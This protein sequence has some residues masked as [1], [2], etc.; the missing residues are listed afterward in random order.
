MKNIPIVIALL[1]LRLAF[2]LNGVAQDYGQEVDRYLHSST[3][4]D[5]FSEHERN[6]PALIEDWKNIARLYSPSGNEILR[7]QYI[8]ERFREY[9]IP[10]AYIDR[11]GN[12]VGLIEGSNGGPTVVF[13]GTM[14]DL[15]TVAEMVK[16][17]DR[18][19]EERNGKLIGPG[20]NIGATCTAILGLA[21]LF[22]LP[23][24]H[25]DGRI[26]IVGVVQEETGLQGIKGFLEDHPGEVDYLVDIMSGIGSVTYGALGIHWFKIHFK[27]ERGHTLSGG[28]PNVTRSV[29]RAVDR[30]FDIPVPT[31]PPEKRTYLNIAML[32]AGKVYNHK[33]DDGWFSV[34]LRSMDNGTLLET[35]KKIFDCVRSVAGEDQREWW[36]ETYSEVPAGQIPGAR[37]SR[38]VRTAEEVTKALGYDVSLSNRGSSNMNVGISLKIPSISV[39]G[40]RG[41]GRDTPEEYANIKPN[42][43]GI[44]LNFL[45]GFMLTNGKID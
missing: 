5:I 20:T 10:N 16:T 18:P 29:A 44:R 45:L 22:T 42:L 3:V 25:F 7:A 21:R 12:A 41:G 34:D 11:S 38:F 32:G 4:Q 26:Y 13:L 1:F 36:I 30:I 39:G 17:Y 24:V 15:A 2:P 31:E 19:I 6:I 23:S 27:G 33:Y 43:E 8:T 14:D 35:K 40:N 37:N 9:N 28:L